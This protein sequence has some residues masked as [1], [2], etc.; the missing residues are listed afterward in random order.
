MRH[1]GIQRWLFGS[2]AAAAIA[3]MSSATL[4]EPVP[5]ADPAAPGE[6]APQ[7]LC[8]GIPP[9]GEVTA[10]QVFGRWV[11]THAPIGLPM[12]AGD[13]VEFRRDGALAT[14]HGV[15][16]FA[17]LRAELTIGCAAGDVTGD[18]RFDGDDKLIWRHDGSEA[19]FLSPAD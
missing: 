17:V 14:A 9:R 15:C 19:V 6:T 12:Q 3:A 4:A 16:R 11:V 1:T 5:V 7:P 8:C 2:L 10:D 18:V 13:R